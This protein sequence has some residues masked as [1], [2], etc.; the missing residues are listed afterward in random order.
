MIGLDYEPITSY[1][2]F[3]FTNRKCQPV[4]LWLIDCSHNSSYSMQIVGSQVRYKSQSILM[5]YTP[6]GGYE[7]PKCRYNYRKCKTLV[8]TG[9]ND[10]DESLI[11]GHT[12]HTKEKERKIHESLEWQRLCEPHQSAAARYK[13]PWD[14]TRFNNRLFVRGKLQTSSSHT[15]AAKWRS[16]MLFLLLSPTPKKKTP[17]QL[18]CNFCKLGGIINS[19]GRFSSRAVCSSS[20]FTHLGSSAYVTTFL[21]GSYP[22]APTSLAVSHYKM[23]W[24]NTTCPK[25]PEDSGP[26]VKEWANFN[27]ANASLSGQWLR[28][29]YYRYTRTPHSNK[30]RGRSE[31][32]WREEKLENKCVGTLSYLS[33]SLQICKT[34]ITAILTTHVS[35]QWSTPTSTTWMH[36]SVIRLRRCGSKGPK[37]KLRCLRAPGRGIKNMSRSNHLALPPD[38]TNQT[39]DREIHAR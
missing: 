6:C 29:V 25:S 21:I 14:I 2:I 35:R 31:Y 10:S 30:L 24:Q 39:I 17:W 1:Q 23:R 13:C 32:R 34:T 22:A 28:Y 4:A 20:F 26:Q 5:L 3:S 15:A 7:E 11:N 9:A 36:T 27:F 16:N 33:S 8:S 19:R 38:L 37:P 18:C 12:P